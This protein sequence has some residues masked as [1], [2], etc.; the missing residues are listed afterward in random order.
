MAYGAADAPYAEESHGAASDVLSTFERV[1][2]NFA[3]IACLLV[4]ALS[5]VDVILRPLHVEFFWASELVPIL[6]AWSVFLA[7]PAVTRTRS[8]LSLDFVGKYI[9]A[10][11]RHGLRIVGYVL[12]L[13]YI[14]AL[15]YFCGRMAWASYVTDLRTPSILR[16]PAFYAQAGVVLGLILLVITQFMMLIREAVRLEANYDR[17]LNNSAGH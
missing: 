12:M 4:A 16:L 9:G 8:H 15:V 7:L 2:R 11:G 6:L 17:Q 14:G 13:T 3:A 10:H 1:A 5:V